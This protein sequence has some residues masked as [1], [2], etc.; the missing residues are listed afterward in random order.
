MPGVSRTTAVSFT[1][2]LLLAVLM[3]LPM[4]ANAADKPWA[5]PA[6]SFSEQNDVSP[7]LYTIEPILQP[8][9]GK[10]REIPLGS[11]VPFLPEG[12][13]PES[14]R[15]DPVVQRF[16]GGILMPAAAQNFEGVNNVNGVYPPDTNG[17]VGPNHYVQTVNLSFA[18]WDK[19]GTLL[20]GPAAT[21]T[22]WSGFG[23]ACETSNH[24]D[25][26]VL[27]DH[28]ANRWLISQF[29]VSG[30]YY[31]CIAI[32]QT[33]D[34]TGSWYRY[35]F[36]VST[37]NMND[38]P[39][40]GVWP[41]GYYMSVN[42]FLNGTSWAGV[43]AGVFERDQM[44][45]GLPARMVYFDVGAVSLDYYSML[46]ADLDGAVPPAGAPNY[47]VEADDNSWGWPADSLRIWQFHVD[48]ATPA[49]STF[50]ANTSFDPNTVLTTAA[51]DS[52]MCSYS[53]SCIPQQ[54][55][56]QG[57]DAVSLR[58]M[59][60]LQYRN[61]GTY[62]AMVTNHTVDADN[63]DHA[64][65][66]WYELRKTTGD[67]AIQQQGTYAPDA[68]HRWMGSIAMDGQGNMA[69]GY[70]V[71]SSTTYPSIRYAGRLVSDPA[72]TLPQAEA[73]IITG[74]G[75]QT[76]TA[77][78]WGDYSMMAVDP[79]DNCTFW[80]TQEYIQTT[81]GAPWR[82][83]IA[84]F[85]FP[86]C[87]SG[88]TGTLQGTV[89]AAGT[90]SPI[91]GA[92]ITATG[93]FSTTTNAS[94]FYQITSMPVGT[95]DVTASKTGYSP[96]TVIGLVITDGLTTTQDFSLSALAPA[97][98]QGTI[99]D[100]SGQDWP[101]YARIDITADGYANTIYTNPVTGQYS[102]DL[103]DTVN[104]TFTASATGYN[105][106]V[107][108][109]T[110]SGNRTED[111]SL[112]VDAGCTAIG[113]QK[114]GYLQDF[115]AGTLPSGWS[116]TDGIGNGQVWQFND[117]GSRTNL[118]GGTGGFA[119]VDSDKYG[120]S[121]S[122][123]T[124][125]VSPAIDFTDVA[126]V[127]LQFDTDFYRYTAEIAD[128]DV[129]NNGGSTWTNV[130]K[131]TGAS[132]R[133]PKHETIDISAIAGNQVSV[134][135]RFH[136]YNASWAWWW[137]VD[138][139]SIGY[140][141][142]PISGGLVTGTVTDA[143]TGLPVSGAT[144]SSDAGHSTTT[145][146]SGQF[147][148]ATTAGSR[149]ITASKSKYT[150]S[151][152]IV[153]VVDKSTVGQD[154]ALTAPLLSYTPTSAKVLIDLSTGVFTTNQ[155]VSLGNAGTANTS[156]T[157]Q[158]VNTY[159]QLL[160]PVQQPALVVKPFKQGFPTSQGLGLP[161]LPVAPPY[162]AGNVV[163]SWSP[164]MAAPWG[165]AYDSV[166]GTVWVGDG[167]G[168]DDKIFEFSASGS[169]TGRSWSYTWPTLSGSGPADAAVNWQTGKIWTMNINSGI[170]NC[171]H[172]IDPATGATGNS[173]CPSG[174]TGFT[175]SQRGLAYDPTTDT[176][177]A[178]SWNDSMVHHF[179][180][181]GAVLDE[182]NVGLPIAGLAYNPDTQHLFVM[183]NAA[184]NL[185]YVLD[186]SNSY[187]I[188]GSFAASQG[189]GDYAGAGLEIDCNGKLWA[190][191]QTTDTVYQIDTG[192]TT[193]VC[194]SPNVA[195]LSET[196][197]S[198]PLNQS[199]NQTVSLG[200]NATGLATGRYTANV[201]A[202]YTSP[203]G[204]EKLPVTMNVINGPVTLF[205]PNNGLPLRSGTQHLIEWGARPEATTFKLMYSTDN[206]LTWKL[207]TK[208]ATGD[209][210][211]W[212]V[213][214][215]KKKKCRVK[216]V[217]YKTV[218]GSL[219]KLGADKSDKPFAIE[220][221]KVLTPNGGE[222]I[223]SGTSFPI[224]WTNNTLKKTPD[225]FAVYLS[226]DGGV[227]YKPVADGAGNPGIYAWTPSVT[228]TRTQCRVK[229][230]LKTAGVVVGT[231]ISNANFT[232]TY[233]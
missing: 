153:G 55:T 138:N 181:D 198:G 92:S 150:D 120:S 193:S 188:V 175:T 161:A 82:T 164:G 170:D 117:P 39:K 20:Y 157:L 70:S 65:I 89:T 124:A 23:G 232:I 54:G 102:V 66:R 191:D 184:P 167:W 125:L 194:S 172:E 111:F 128:V 6:V 202:N 100:G 84:S 226:T 199:T 133:G 119:I 32:S 90:G 227:T 113:Y 108:S 104:Y 112:T 97:T 67:W 197:A 94:G 143:N 19:T 15:P 62:Q 187:A 163:A 91:N 228:K 115:S 46:P 2:F 35:A 43:G 131:K 93:G 213:P 77:G 28:L 162:A 148:F 95:Y 87:T 8:K 76:G 225:A 126:T 130:W 42:Q 88:P 145:N 208:T 179:D 205:S 134:K 58:L 86:S 149:T 45:S 107:K 169:A 185:I 17:D 9:T 71:S 156:Y 27:Y 52:D 216:I 47:F 50:G 211:L 24:G 203:Y 230:D 166:N 4:Q 11:I 174:S 137:E 99:V 53:R 159:R 122:Q 151:G 10:I 37:N 60:R 73:T 109:F 56:T 21:N 209:S 207:I 98:V 7:P 51:F 190:V 210:Y 78:R 101:L 63:T 201:E 176:W 195:W 178:G 215:T 200:F 154:F 96:S 136:Y 103:P 110:L 223:P 219:V 186:A 146:A 57:L 44:L 173:I 48:W 224:Q 22:L 171:I 81:G 83:R 132:Y 182:V 25:P 38:Y 177:F 74:A 217:A 80:Y 121:G 140:S 40:L 118:T 106:E 129:S 189:F 105:N 123:D 204:K 30:P 141:C 180:S 142:T 34:P 152:Q 36:Q 79:S 160:G 144:V 139:V 68:L 16:M 3:I 155:N 221:V 214:V 218:G 69:L 18:I 147:S 196:P 59:H 5:G 158:E 183:T 220:A 29:A 212:N 31:E 13:A 233:P 41:D 64:G 75:S 231:D 14:D 206:G 49:N 116:I 114:T 168:A 222:M 1:L 135:V 85:K 26:I 165:I 127:S 33:G 12:R 72:N 61:F 229:V 192:E